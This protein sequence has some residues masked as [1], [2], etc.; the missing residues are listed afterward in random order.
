MAVYAGTEKIGNRQQHVIKIIPSGKKSDI[1]LATWWIDCK[2]GNITR[3]ESNT[4]DQGSF[5]VDMKY[6]RAT[7]TLPG[8]ITIRF[9]IEGMSIPLKFIGKS[10]G[11]D[12]DSQKAKGRQEGRVTI[13]FSGYRINGY[14]DDAVFR[15]EEISE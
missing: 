4:R 7:D 9:G 1:V 3:T 15:K 14:I 5:V 12:I 11:M 2:T 13:R 8:E 10:N 6:N